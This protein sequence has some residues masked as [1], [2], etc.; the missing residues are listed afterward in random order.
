[1]QARLTRAKAK[2]RKASIPY[3]V[4]EHHEL[5]DRL[6]AV[7]DVVL[8][9]YNQG[10]IDV[11]YDRAVFFFDKDGVLIEHAISAPTDEDS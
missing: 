7:N 11:A 4:P 6:A 3:R 8:L 2:V 9:I 10:D 5:P 1:M